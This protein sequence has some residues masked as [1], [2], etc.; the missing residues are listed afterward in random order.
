MLGN[1][2][3]PINHSLLDLHFTYAAMALVF[4]PVHEHENTQVTKFENVKEE[5]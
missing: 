4:I 5:L 3:A 1:R 2:V